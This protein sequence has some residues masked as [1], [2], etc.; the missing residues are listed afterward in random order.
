MKALIFI[1]NLK[2]TLTEIEASD[3]N[4]VFYVELNHRL[5]QELKAYSVDKL[6]KS[7]MNK[8]RMQNFSN[9]LLSRDIFNS[10]IRY[11]IVKLREFLI[12]EESY[13]D[14]ISKAIDLFINSTRI[15]YGG[16]SDIESLLI[17]EIARCFESWYRP[18]DLF[19]IDFAQSHQLVFANPR[20]KNWAVSNLGGYFYQ[21]PPFEAIAF[22]CGLEIVLTLERHKRVF[23][24]RQLLEELLKSRE[25]NGSL[26]K[27]HHTWPYSLGLLGIITGYYR[28]PENCKVSDFGYRVLLY[29]QSHLEQF[30]DIIMLLLESEA[31]GLKYSLELDLKGILA[32]IEEASVL[33]DDQKKSVRNAIVDYE[34]GKYLDSLRVINPILEGT[35]D[36]ALAAIGIQ[37]PTKRP[38]GM[39]K[40]REMLKENNLISTRLAVGLEICTTIRNKVLHGN[41]LEEDVELVSPLFPIVLNHLKRLVTELD[42][43]L[44]EKSKSTQ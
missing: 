3:G 15:G 14:Y 43:N 17:S 34:N 38:W 36:T 13:F 37:Q 24:S 6:R 23:I 20:E 18:E 9:D 35:L 22:L 27:S 21:L 31:T 12:E 42:K 25:E 19:L 1:Q 7:S 26:Q 33:I 30:Q 29:V 10:R 16:S 28:R 40:K 4:H 41:I 44:S 5:I 39:A 2:Q 11:C 8:Q 32:V